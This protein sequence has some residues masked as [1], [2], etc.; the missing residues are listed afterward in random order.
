MM[1]DK[2]KI[3]LPTAYFP[4]L[5][6]FACLIRIEHAEIEQM[7]TFPK[8]TIRN[9]FEIM[10]AAGKAKLIVPITRP[11]GNHTLTKDIEIC[12]REPWR[13]QHWKTLQTAYSSSPFFSYYADIIHPLFESEETMLIKHNLSILQTVNSLIGT[14]LS[15]ELTRDYLKMP[16]EGPDYRKQFSSKSKLPLIEFPHYPQVFEHKYGFMPN[17]SILDLLFNLG[18]EA[19]R[20]IEK[21]AVSSRQSTRA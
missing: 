14:D 3:L 20:Y 2:D 1:T 21:S 11:H 18:P 4:P 10:T 8:Q 17:L 6:Y 5:S 15:V 13:E 12:Y 9:R 16:L 19:G 7:E